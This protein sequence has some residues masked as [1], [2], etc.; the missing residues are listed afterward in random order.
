MGA[1]LCGYVLV[2]PSKLDKKKVE[3]AKK[4]MKKLKSFLEQLSPEPTA[5]EISDLLK[6]KVDNRVVSLLSSYVEDFGE[7][8]PDPDVINDFVDLW[9][10]GGYRDMM[11]RPFKENL[12]IVV[13]G[14]MTWGD[15]PEEGSA[16]HVC[17]QAARLGLFELLG[18]E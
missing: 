16:W 1:D 8:V 15:G 10:S 14:E 12:Q 4:Q 5:K 11:S 9:T 2:G 7:G 13:A 18:I 6:G 17:E 3:Y